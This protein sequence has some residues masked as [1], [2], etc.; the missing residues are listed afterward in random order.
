MVDIGDLGGGSARAYDVSEDSNV[1]VGESLRGAGDVHAFRWTQSGGMRSLGTLGGSSSYATSTSPDGSVIVGSSR[2]NT[3]DSSTHAFRWT[4]SGGMQDLGGG[5]QSH[6]YGISADSNIIVGR[7]D[8]AAFIWDSTNGMR[9]LYNVLS[10]NGADL[11]G[12]TNLSYATAIS[13]D[14]ST[15]VGY[16]SYNGKTTGYIAKIS[17]AIIP[18]PTTLS[19]FALGGVAFLH[20]KRAKRESFPKACHQG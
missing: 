13:G 5:F 9:S 19:L 16:G 12:W 4:E 8:S 17:T 6:A 14:G 15:I 10:T 3:T 18:E 11:T 1:I 7:N 2:Y 20:R